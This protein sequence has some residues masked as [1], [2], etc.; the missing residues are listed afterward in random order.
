[1]DSLAVVLCSVWGGRG[2]ELR[3][4]AGGFGCFGFVGRHMPATLISVLLR[5]R[6]VEAR[7]HEAILLVLHPQVLLVT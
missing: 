5:G 7:S 3:G 6:S 2:C 1:M 4:D